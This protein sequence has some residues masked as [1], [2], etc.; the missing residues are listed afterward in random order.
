VEV[1]GESGCAGLHGHAV[2]PLEGG[3]DEAVDPGG[4]SVPQD[5]VLG[6]LHAGA[7]AAGRVEFPLD[8]A[9]DVA[10]GAGTE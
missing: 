8:G 2:V 10:A 3:P 1:L 4:E 5:D 7:L 9:V 6:E